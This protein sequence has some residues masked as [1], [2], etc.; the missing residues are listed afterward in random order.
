MNKNY[1]IT[2][3]NN[4]FQKQIERLEEEA[5]NTGWFDG[6]IIETPKTIQGFYNK[7]K[8]FIDSNERGW[9][10]WIWKPYVILR[11]LREMNDGDYLFYTDAGATILKHRES[12]FNDY[13][14]MM[15]NSDKP[16]ITFAIHE[17][18]ERGLQK[19]ASLK[20]FD[21]EN[22]AAFL[23]SGQVESGV[24]ICKKTEFVME[25]MQTW[26]DY[27]LENEYELAHDLDCEDGE[28]YR[29]DQSILSILCK[30][31]NTHILPGYN[32]YGMGPF[33]SSRM[34]DSG[35]RLKGPDLFR[36]QIGYNSENPAHSTY[37]T[38]ANDLE[39]IHYFHI[40]NIGDFSARFDMQNKTLLDI[41]MISDLKPRLNFNN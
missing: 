22:D 29:H 34:V 26:L 16:I 8:N 15:A 11:Q 33:F 12:K 24:V 2:F 32:V 36:M 40:P 28:G 3:G 4:H 20:R 14:E 25:F 38:W 23:E 21:L 17:Y 27:L 19:K 37:Y 30:L 39:F 13:I 35:Q 41:Q 7:H 31:H 5:K 9:G 18:Y 6:V 10:Y 1:F